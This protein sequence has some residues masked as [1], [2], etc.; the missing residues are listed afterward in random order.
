MTGFLFQSNQTYY[1]PYL[2]VK[3]AIFQTDQRLKQACLHSLIKPLLHLVPN[4]LL[5]FNFYCH[6]EHAFHHNTNVFLMVP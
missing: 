6:P 4:R 1:M 3:S 2:K 5:Y